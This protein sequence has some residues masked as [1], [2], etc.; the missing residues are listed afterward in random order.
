MSSTPDRLSSASAR[1]DPKASPDQDQD[2][3]VAR[4]V[5]PD[6]I[7]LAQTAAS[8]LRTGPRS[9]NRNSEGEPAWEGHRG[10]TLFRSV[11]DSGRFILS[12]GGQHWSSRRSCR[13]QRAVRVI[14]LTST[15]AMSP[16]AS[17]RPESASLLY[18]WFATERPAAPAPTTRTLWWF[19]EA[20][21]LHQP[22]SKGGHTS[23]R[24][25]GQLSSRLLGRRRN[26]RRWASGRAQRAQD[27][28][29]H[30][31]VAN[32]RDVGRMMDMAR[33]RDREWDGWRC[34]SWVEGRSEKR[35]VELELN[36]T[37]SASTQQRQGRS[38][39]NPERNRPLADSTDSHAFRLDSCIQIHVDTRRTFMT[40]PR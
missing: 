26:S 38:P 23:R 13:G 3:T 15:S 17:R 16:S 28:S 34:L 2:L 12:A 11:A 8:V 33:T 18:S 29:T 22:R 25:G 1:V 30:A 19:V 6:G 32:R 24:T 14:V 21:D 31:A 39:T 35:E 7:G 27:G 40:I 9:P 4:R 5:I 20:A 10:R 37:S 36:P